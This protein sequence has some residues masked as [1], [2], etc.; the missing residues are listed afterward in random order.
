MEEFRTTGGFERIKEAQAA[1]EKPTETLLG[2]KEDVKT[3]ACP[4]CQSQE[5]Q[6]FLTTV[7]R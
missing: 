3:L 4:F 1:K 6:I 7:Y 5:A 2:K